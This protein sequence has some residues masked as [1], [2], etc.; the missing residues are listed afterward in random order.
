MGILYKYLYKF[1]YL[2]FRFDHW[3]K[4]HKQKTDE[5]NL[6]TF[7]YE[8][9]VTILLP[10][11]SLPRILLGDNRTKNILRFFERRKAEPLLRKLVY[12]FYQ[13]K[14]VKPDEG[15]I[16]IGSW[17]GDNSLPWATFLRDGARVFAI[18]PSTENLSFAEELARLNDI[19]NIDFIPAVCADAVGIPLAFYGAIDHATFSV[20]VEGSS[21]HLS[22]TLDKIISDNGAPKI[23]LIHVDVEGFE[24]SV[25]SGA[26]QIL[27]GQKPL[28]VFEQH[29]SSEPYDNVVEF[30]KSF[31]YRVFMINEVLPGYNPDCRN[32]I[33][34]IEN[35]Y[36]FGLDKFLTEL[37]NHDGIYSAAVGPEL[38]EL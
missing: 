3:L 15:I 7:P 31:D 25:L 33:A 24:L 1:S 18:D 38:I 4:I 26:K 10:P 23:G 30:L 32:F 22:T 28:I 14:I 21:S 5:H 34:V 35:E 17:L 11:T 16:D 6:V 37:E 13:K 12:E 36:K 19:S 2:V 29:I 27:Q 9:H 20:T 8:G